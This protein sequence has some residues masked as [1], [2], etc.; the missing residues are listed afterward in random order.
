MCLNNAMVQERQPMSAAIPLACRLHHPW[1]PG[2][3]AVS[4]E[5]C[6]CAAAQA[7]RGGHIRV[8]CGAVGCSEVWWSP[9]H[10]PIGIIG[11]HRHG[12]R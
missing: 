1:R 9:R 2:T 8:A 5:P 12:Y 6:D 4:W 10:H 7:A 3:V 11:H